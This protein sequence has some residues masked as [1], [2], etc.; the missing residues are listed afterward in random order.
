MITVRNVV[1][2]LCGVYIT[3]YLYTLFK[4]KFSI[5]FKEIM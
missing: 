2:S 4:I 5:G 1:M 3:I